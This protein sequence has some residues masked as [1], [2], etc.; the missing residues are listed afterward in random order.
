MGERERQRQTESGM[1]EES[2]DEG[3]ERERGS[4]VGER[5]REGVWWGRERERELEIKTLF[6]KDCSFGLVKI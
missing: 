4:L 6:Y 1:R 3:G 5:E 2:G